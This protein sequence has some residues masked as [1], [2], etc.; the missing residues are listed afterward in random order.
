MLGTIAKWAIN[1]YQG[2]AKDPLPIVPSNVNAAE[3]FFQ[4]TPIEHAKGSNHGVYN[5]WGQVP[6]RV[7]GDVPVKYYNLTGLGISH[8]GDY[9]VPDW[10]QVHVVPTLG[11]G[12]SFVNPGLLTGGLDGGGSSDSFCSADVP[13]RCRAGCGG[14]ALRFDHEFVEIHPARPDGRRCGWELDLNKSSAGERNLSHHRQ[15]GRHRGSRMASHFRDAA[16]VTWEAESRR[17]ESWGMRGRWS[18]PGRIARS[19]WRASRRPPI[20]PHLTC[21]GF[22]GVYRSERSRFHQSGPS[23]L[24]SASI[25]I[26]ASLSLASISGFLAERSLVSCGSEARL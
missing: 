15:V 12:S 11:E 17:P 6:V 23:A 2:Q 7:Q 20:P 24:T 18:G 25:R 10:Y 3:V 8:G 21:H 19:G 5:L 13:G 22:E 14:S 16:S 4:H 26:R 9:S 1:K